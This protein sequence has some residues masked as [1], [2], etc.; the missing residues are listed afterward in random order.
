MGLSPRQTAELHELLWQLRTGNATT[1]ELARLER[2]VCE[3]PRAR[4]IYVRYMHLCADLYWNGSETCKG[5]GARGEGR[6][7]ADL[8]IGRFGDL[9]K[10]EPP[11]AI[12][13]PSSF[14]SPLLT[15]FVGGPV[16][17]YMVATVVLCLMLL[18]G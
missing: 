18:G 17:S 16:F 15:P 4:A 3:D 13:S 8:E 7:T 5:P 12:P 10:A 1:K 6:E 11:L 14:P 2:L 9:A